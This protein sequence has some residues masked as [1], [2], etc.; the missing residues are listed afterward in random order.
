MEATMTVNEFPKLVIS[1]KYRN[2]I[3]LFEEENKGTVVWEK[4]S[5]FAVGQKVTFNTEGMKTIN[6][7]ISGYEL[8]KCKVEND[9]E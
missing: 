4:D 8:K 5:I 9:S 1:K 3:V 7:S 6:L 2:L